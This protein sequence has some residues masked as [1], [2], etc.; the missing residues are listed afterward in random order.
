MRFSMLLLSAILA[1]GALFGQTQLV[2]DNFFP[3]PMEFKELSSV[4]EEREFKVPVQLAAL[5]QGALLIETGLRHY[6]ERSYTLADSGTLSIEVLT[7]PDAR[8]AY[9]LLTILSNAPLQ[10][11]PPGDFYSA[12]SESILL[13]SGN[14][15]VRVRS[16]AVDL[17]RHVALSVANRIGSSR[18]D[19]PSLIKHFPKD[20]C[21][22]STARYFLASGAL[23]SFGTPVAGSS[24]T[25]PPDVEVAQARCASPGR[26][27]TMTLLHFPTIVLAEEYF[28]T[29]AIFPR[30][31]SGSLNIYTRQT[32]PIVAIL[33]G[34]FA[35]D[36]ADKTLGSIT[37]QYS[38]KWIYDRANQ[39]R[40]IWG[41]PVRILGTVVHSLVF[42]ALLC[43]GSIAVG[44][45]LAAGRMYFRK[46]FGPSESSEFI[47]LKINED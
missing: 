1:A 24:L 20:S 41:V 33:E 4:R 45:G 26:N 19:P 46:R 21:D 23:K 30:D 44:I 32:G 3:A 15:F 39:S 37:F 6:A 12:G 5:E 36:S 34:N 43:L 8:S 29:A 25:V 16:A 13:I 27:G 7:F 11:G 31:P 22:P 47:R 14:R 2:S 10:P 9:S 40:T 38:I 42:T 17:A 35:P 18:P 28:D